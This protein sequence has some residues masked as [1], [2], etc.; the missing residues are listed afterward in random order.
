VGLPDLDIDAERLADVIRN[1]V[2]ND[3]ITHH[4]ASDL[5]RRYNRADHHTR[6]AIDMTLIAMCGYSLPTLVFHTRNRMVRRG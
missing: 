6:E 4:D 2:E 5:L 3:Y 1:E